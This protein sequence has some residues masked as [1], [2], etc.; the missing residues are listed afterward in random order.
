MKSKYI[1]GICLLSF[2]IFFSSRSKAQNT[3]NQ[4]PQKREFRG[5]WFPT[6]TN[7]YWR[8]MSSQQIQEDIIKTLDS[9]ASI[10]INAVLFQVRPQAD[11]F[12]VSEYEPWSRFLTGTQGK[13]PDPFWDPAAFVI[14][15]CHNRG[16]EMHAWIN[17]YRVTSKESEVLAKG[18]LYHKKPHLFVKYGTQIYFNPAEPESR[19]H[20][21][22]VI[23]DFVKR[24]NVD[25]IHFD[26]YFYP[27]R[28]AGKEFPDEKSFIKYHKKDG[29]SKNQKDDW[30]RNNVTIL[31]KAI[32]DTIKKIKPWVKFGI[33]PFGVW[34]NASK[35]S[36]GSNSNAG[37]T[38]YDDLFADIRLWCIE[39]YIDYNVPQ[40]YWS[41]G[42]KLADYKPLIEW[43]SK[44]KFKPQLYIG[45]SLTTLLD[46]E[47]PD[48]SREN[49]LYKKINLLREQNN[50][51][52]NIWWPGTALAKDN[53]LMDSLR[54][55]YQ[56][57]P[58]LMPLYP[59]I[60]SIPPAPVI[61]LRQEGNNLMWDTEECTDPLNQ[62]VFFAIYKFNKD[63]EIDINDARKLLLITNKK[64]Y[65]LP[66]VENESKF[67]IVAIDRLWNE[68]SFRY[69]VNTNLV[70]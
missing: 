21:I 49:Q 9:L 8:N 20:T 2:C 59:Q 14:E 25:A 35:D 42:H 53:K 60:D 66:R 38:N 18:H 64:V 50:I 32:N 26:D 51:D 45:Q 62:A 23:A 33:S 17:P 41:I 15:Q 30:R 16:M 24:Y 58:A 36:L 3:N 22:K 44:N 28:I 11:A 29:F 13:A 5:A 70:P 54:L 63:E 61:N 6:V 31:V 19:E 57:Y 39:G 4:T 37:Q 65:Q 47:L 7:G 52:G 48:K 69:I 1:I 43:W 40:L 34:R 56:K 10:H 68:S 55:N 27:Y 12:F 46:T 67:V